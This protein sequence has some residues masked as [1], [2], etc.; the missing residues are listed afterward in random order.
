VATLADDLTSKLIEFQ[1]AI[2]PNATSIAALYN[3]ANPMNLDF[4]KRLREHAG[5]LGMSVAGIEVRSRDDLEAAFAALRR[6]GR[7][8][9]RLSRIQA[10]STSAT[11]SPHWLS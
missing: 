4:L 8:C 10:C 3:P 1:R 11:A 5:A 7:M 6:L 9:F 2:L